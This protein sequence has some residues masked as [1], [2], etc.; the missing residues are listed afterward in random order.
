MKKSPLKSSGLSF[1]N[2]KNNVIMILS[3][4]KKVA[5]IILIICLLWIYN[6]YNLYEA[7]ADAVKATN[8]NNVNMPTPTN[9]DTPPITTPGPGKVTTT[10][11][12]QSPLKASEDVGLYNDEVSV[13]TNTKLYIQ[14]EVA[15]MIPMMMDT[16]TTNQ[17]RK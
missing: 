14:K 17:L 8:T 2:F 4:W 13:N 5:G 9:T 11:M 6:H 1:R 15:S 7:F 10:N 16:F 12:N 3:D